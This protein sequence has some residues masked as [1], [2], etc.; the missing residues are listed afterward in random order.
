MFLD[1]FR[2]FLKRRFGG[3]FLICNNKIY[4]FS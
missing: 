1:D 4:F 3:K 2:K